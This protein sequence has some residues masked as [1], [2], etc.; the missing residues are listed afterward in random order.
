MGDRPDHDIESDR[1]Y[2]RCRFRRR[3]S[4]KTAYE[5]MR[6]AMIRGIGRNEPTLYTVCIA[7]CEF[8]RFSNTS[9]VARCPGIFLQSGVVVQ[10]DRA[11]RKV[12]KP[13]GQEYPAEFTNLRANH[14]TCRYRIQSVKQ[15]DVYRL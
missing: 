1:S 13:S 10:T 14:G 4:L 12:E 7:G 8:I 3:G 9:V 15:V 2:D 11:D 5:A 6:V